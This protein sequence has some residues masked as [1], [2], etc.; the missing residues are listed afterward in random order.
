[1]LTCSFFNTKKYMLV[2]N[3][4]EPNVS[5]MGTQYK[6]GILYSSTLPL[7]RKNSW[8]VCNAEAAE[9][10]PDYQRCKQILRAENKAFK[11]H[12]NS[13]YATFIDAS[14]RICH[15]HRSKQTNTPTSSKQANESVES[16]RISSHLRNRQRLLNLL[17]IHVKICKKS[18]RRKF[19]LCAV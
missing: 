5:L 6:R 1:M 10:A 18:A 15:L 4:F 12:M 8:D 3:G 14:K 2:N 17:R 11:Y 9:V 19:V 13:C 7:F 16:Q